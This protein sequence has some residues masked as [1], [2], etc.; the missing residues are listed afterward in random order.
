MD[1]DSEPNADPRPFH[2]VPVMLDRVVELLRPVPPGVVV[3]ATLGGAGH[4]RALLDA[5]PHVRILGIDQDEEAVAAA[6]AALAP[7]GDRAVVRHLRFDQLDEAI[8]GI[9]DDGISG[10]L[11]DLGV[12]SHQLDEGR[13]GMSFRKD[14]PLDMRMDRRRRRTA[15][16]VVND[17]SAER[18]AETLDRYGDERY[19]RRI[20]A[21]I[22]AARPIS[23]TG[24]LA[25][26]VAGAIPAPAR[27][28]SKGHPAR[29]TF[30]ALRIEVNEELSI[31]ADSL[32]RA[33]SLLLPG[34]RCVAM[35]YHSGEDRIVKDRFR[36]AATGGCTCP[37]KLPC[38][39]GAEPTVRLLKR[40]AERPDSVEI[41]AN[42]RAESVRVR[43]V[44]RLGPET[45][46]S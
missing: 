24:E 9:A 35:S 4:A 23:T 40:G 8:A 46:A 2:H 29:R 38:V 5:L 18:L 21:A 27:R 37:P 22:V 26:V 6:Q 31:L 14:A 45:K 12:S 17:Y 41:T 32:D 44:E 10:A 34:G 19:A 15:A 25:E 11:F 13:R 30:Q 43:A 28:T 39:C 1:P 3:D 42:P 7:Y 16:D 20:A 33:I 36:V